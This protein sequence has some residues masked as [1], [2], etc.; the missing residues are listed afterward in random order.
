MAISRIFRIIRLWGKRRRAE[1]VI[2][3]APTR[4]KRGELAFGDA[5]ERL[6]IAKQDGS[7]VTFAPE[8]GGPLYQGATGPVGPTGPQGPS[9]L[10]GVAGP[11]GATG[12]RGITGVTGATGPRGSTGPIGPAGGPTGA[13]GPTGPTGIGVTGPTGPAGVTGPSG[14]QGATGPVG[15]A[16][17]PTGPSGPQGATGPVGPQGATGP[18]GPAGGAIF[19]VAT[20]PYAATI[21]T[22]S[23]QA[24]IFRIVLTGD[25]TLANPINATAGRLLRWY[26]F[27][28]SVGGRSVTL[29]S[30][31]VI[32]DS[33]LSPLP[34]S[35]EP[36]TLDVFTASYDANMNKWLVFM[37]EQAYPYSA[38]SNSTS[39][40]SSS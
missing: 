32:P 5:E 13:T 2:N 26:L 27:Q 11:R 25:L 33:M 35:T 39:S 18:V 30:Q 31:F 17:G 37:F 20:L 3:G 8:D 23:D 22:D 7:I 4:L 29:G 15:P 38:S 1:N 10:N 9:G 21:T 14:P 28:D 24:D 6:Y 12:P 16:G 34:F 40:S 36:N 19:S